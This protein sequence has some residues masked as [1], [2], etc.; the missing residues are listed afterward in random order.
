MVELVPR[1]RPNSGDGCYV[2]LGWWSWL[3]IKGTTEM[4]KIMYGRDG[5]FGSMFKAQQR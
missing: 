5:G 4:M 1:E 3:H 2:G